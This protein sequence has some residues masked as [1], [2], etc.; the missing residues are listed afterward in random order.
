MKYI[1]SFSESGGSYSPGAC[2]PVPTGAAPGSATAICS[3]LES[4]PTRSTRTGP[5]T[6]A[7]MFAE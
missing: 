5:D 6:P 2:R 3:T 7:G 1:G 4:R